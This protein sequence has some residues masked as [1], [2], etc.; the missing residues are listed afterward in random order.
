MAY[1]TDDIIQ[2]GKISQPL[3]ILNETKKKAI[4]GASV[5]K[6]HHIKLYVERKSVEWYNSQDTVDLDILY[7]ISNWL[8]ALEGIWG[9]KAQF[10]DGGSGGI[11]APVTSAPTTLPDPLD[12]IVTSIAS[13]TS[14]LSNGQSTVTL[15]GTNG[16]PNLRG[17]NIEFTR[18]NL[19]QNTTPPG[20][21]SS[22]YSWNRVTG[23]FVAIPG[24][25]TDER[26]RILI[27]S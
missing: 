24:V 1:T 12:W 17:F 6:D 27:A 18:N 9:I 15:D 14:P 26:L 25:V 21:G 19:V 11:V 3:S 5:D 16:M 4:S 8:F 13:G 20:D 2:W 10:I 7:Q 22:Y 23:E